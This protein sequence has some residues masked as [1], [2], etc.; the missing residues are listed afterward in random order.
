MGE[1]C[2]SNAGGLAP[3]APAL[4][5]ALAAVGWRLSEQ[6]QWVPVCT[7][8]TAKQLQEGLRTA[9]AAARTDEPPYESV[10]TE[11]TAFGQAAAP[12]ARP[13]S[14]AGRQVAPER[15][16]ATLLGWWKTTARD[17]GAWPQAPSQ[18]ARWDC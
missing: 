6:Q 7:A 1:D 4:V 5:A 16:H 10:R 9:A 18:L 14:R 15:C 11:R 2:P 8:R 13:S 3:V 12:R 17:R